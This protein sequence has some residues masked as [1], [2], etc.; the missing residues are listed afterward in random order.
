MREIEEI[1]TPKYENDIEKEKVFTKLD[2][3]IRDLLEQ[4]V[5][6]QK[7]P[8]DSR[9]EWAEAGEKGNSMCRLR[10]A[11]EIHVHYKSN[12]KDVF[13]CGKE[14]K[15]HMQK[16]YGTDEVEYSH[17]EPDF[18]PFERT[19][20]RSEFADYLRECHGKEY[21]LNEIEDGHV[22]VEHMNIKRDGKNGTFAEASEEMA[23]RLGGGVTRQDVDGYMEVNDLTWHECGDRRTIRM[24]PTE[25]NQVFGHTGGIGI[26]KDFEALQGSIRRAAG[27]GRLYLEHEAVE[28][29]TEKLGDAVQNRYEMNREEKSVL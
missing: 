11:A 25:I 2:G 6:K 18:S 1:T 3:I 28:G 5:S 16:L 22:I 4:N 9:V 15:E 20:G 24:I 14:F 21:A 12:G 8:G 26:E 27:G 13:Y 19:I 10:D 29:R 23:R 7:L 17:K